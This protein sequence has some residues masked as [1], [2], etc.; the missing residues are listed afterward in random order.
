MDFSLSHRYSVFTKQIFPQRTNQEALH[1]QASLYT[2]EPTQLSFRLAWEDI[3]FN[4]KPFI[5]VFAGGVRGGC[6]FQKAFSPYKSIK[7]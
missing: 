1:N 6:F 3:N 2:R 7:A 4:K 5:K